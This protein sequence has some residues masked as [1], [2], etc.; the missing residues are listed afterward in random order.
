MLGAILGGI[1][2]IL[3]AK[4]QA[5]AAKAQAKAMD[6]ATEVQREALQP[7]LDLF[8]QFGMPG[9]KTALQGI[10]SSF[11]YRPGATGFNPD[12]V[13]TSPVAGTSLG[14]PPRPMG[15]EAPSRQPVEQEG[16]GYY[17]D[18]GRQLGMTADP[19][20]QARQQIMARAEAMGL[21]PAAIQAQLNRLDMQQSEQMTNQMIDAQRMGPQMLLQAL[22]PAL[23]A[24]GAALQGAGQL[25]STEMQRAQMIGARPNPWTDALVGLG[26]IIGQWQNRPRVQQPVQSPW[27]TNVTM[28]GPSAPI[29]VPSQYYMTQRQFN[30]GK[31]TF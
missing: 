2:S 5:K 28:R 18:L 30:T 29:T 15:S 17:A 12:R 21:P 9:Y 7:Q 23:G 4:S 19:Y 14:Q 6:R 31:W 11:G 24:G 20:N 13:P 16:W 27:V 8:K 10:L 25:A 1:G 26:S 3:G 22:A